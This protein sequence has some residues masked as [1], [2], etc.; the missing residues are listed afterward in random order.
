M[1]FNDSSISDPIN[2][3]VPA[4]EVDLEAVVGP[5]K[6]EADREKVAAGPEKAEVDREKAEAAPEAVAAVEVAPE[7]AAGHEEVAVG[8]ERVEVDQEVAVG[9]DAVE[10]DREE[11]AAVPDLVLEVGQRCQKEEDHAHEAVQLCPK[12]V[13]NH[14]REVAKDRGL[15]DLHN[16]VFS[17]C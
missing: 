3:D 14:V 4:V 2:R 1:K 6:V 5:E 16:F 8:R 15:L 9:Q 7:A 11:V 10:V 13:V 12:E 17:I